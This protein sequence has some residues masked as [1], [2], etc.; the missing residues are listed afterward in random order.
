MRNGKRNDMIKLQED[1]QNY[2]PVNEQE[3][4][5]KEIMLAFL[6]NHEDCFSRDNLIA[7]FTTSIWTVNKE[8]TKTLL[9]YHNLYDSWAWLGG[10]ADGCEDLTVV[11]MKELQEETGVKNAR[12]VSDAILSLE[13][14]TVA[15]HVKKGKY[16]PSHLHLNV[17]YLA[18]AD[19]SE[20]LVVK[21]DENQAVKWFTFEEALKAST[22]PWMIEHI[23]KKLIPKS[24]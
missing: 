17:T 3:E 15:G 14:L 10:H 21:E 8:R 12:L 23:Y 6:Q 20:T 22:E 2:M 16:V 5:D 4:R 13:I 7:H 1:I 24:K 18:E 11:A 9:A 19:E